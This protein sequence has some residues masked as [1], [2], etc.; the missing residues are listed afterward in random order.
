MVFRP[1]ALTLECTSATSALATEVASASNWVSASGR[2]SAPWRAPATT[3][4]LIMVI[5][6]D[7]GGKRNRGRARGCLF[8][9]LII[10]TTQM[11]DTVRT[12]VPST[13]QLIPDT[14]EAPKVPDVD[15]TLKARLIEIGGFYAT[16]SLSGF[17]GVEAWCMF[18]EF[19]RTIAYTRYA[20]R[21]KRRQ[22]K[23]GCIQVKVVRVDESRGLADVRVIGRP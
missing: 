10:T 16:M 5:G 1:R 9:P 17:P 18:P 12:L 3:L 22:Q 8:L 23:D 19:G 6:K 21:L 20:Q 2:I 13:R 7:G 4:A 15:A 11:A 14:T